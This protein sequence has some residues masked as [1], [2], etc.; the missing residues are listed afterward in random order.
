MSTKKTTATSRSVKAKTEVPEKT[1]STADRKAAEAQLLTLVDKF[2]PAHLPLLV[3]VRKALRKRLPTAI[4]VVYEYRDSFV[5]S[6]TPNERGY[7]G[8]LALRGSAK[9]VQL[10]FN[11]GK[12]LSDPEKLLQGSGKQ[13]RL[14]AVENK[15]T[16]SQP[17]VAR[18]IDQ[19]LTLNPVPFAS[20]GRGAVLIRSTTASKRTS[21]K[22]APKAIKVAK[23]SGSRK[24]KK[25]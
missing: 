14:I 2:A 12:E 10:Y 23:A 3:A 19:A 18:L 9:G 25:D 16:L 4:E 17:G 8:V 21:P 24:G 6:Y 5:I 15:S 13:T 11:R 22:T 7:E 1:Q 20:T